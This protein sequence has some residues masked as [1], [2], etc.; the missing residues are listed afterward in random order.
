MHAV[1][2]INFIF[3]RRKYRTFYCKYFKTKCHIARL[4]R[5]KKKLNNRKDFKE[6]LYFYALFI[7]ICRASNNLWHVVRLFDLIRVLSHPEYTL[8]TSYVSIKLFQIGF[9]EE[10]NFPGI[11]DGYHIAVYF[12]ILSKNRL[13][14]E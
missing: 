14:Y 4:I 2:I 5:I 1:I 3:R 6:K 9:Q 10:Y 7:D 13:R 11:S 12:T 8:C